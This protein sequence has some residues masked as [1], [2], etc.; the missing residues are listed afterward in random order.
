[1]TVG[2]PGQDVNRVRL[3]RGLDLPQSQ[4]PGVAITEREYRRLLDRLEGCKPH[5]W[6]DFWL[7]GAGI[8]G[9]LAVAAIVTVLALPATVP[10]ADRDILKMLVILGVVVLVL[11][12]I[13]YFTQ[14]R[15]HGE[16]I[17]ELKTDME[18]HAG[19]AA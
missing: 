13:A 7:A 10:S 14:R 6:S 9:G 11:C 4:E 17:D 19:P 18:M 8:G 16:L 1:V 2:E 5:G 15:Q 12:L 3:N